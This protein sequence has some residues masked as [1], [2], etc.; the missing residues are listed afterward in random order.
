MV[1]PIDKEHIILQTAM[2]VF[3]EKG[4]HGAKMQEIA[5]RAGINKA[6]LHYYFRS[7]D[8]LYSQIFD[9]VFGRF[10]IEISL[11]LDLS[12]SFV[13]G[14]QYFIN[15]FHELLNKN[16]KIPV[17]MARELGEGG[18]IV[19]GVLAKYSAEKT[20]GP[21]RLL[22]F[23]RNAQRKGEVRNELDPHQVLITLMGSIIYYFFAES[24]ITVIFNLPENFDR[25]TFLENRKK[26]IFDI[27]YNGIKPRGEGE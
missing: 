26:A 1:K 20:K 12:A 24:L 16:P 19:S 18:E 3:I 11:K 22:E 9:Q 21:A 4:R 8:N 25:N 14:L 6:L 23:I 17:F 7:K 5:D 27:I 2:D 13:N 10:V 15:E